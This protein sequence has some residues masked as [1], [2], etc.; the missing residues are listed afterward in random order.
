MTQPRF[1]TT[2][3]CYSPNVA[4]RRSTTNN[5]LSHG[6]GHDDT[7]AGGHVH[8]TTV[9][10]RAPGPVGTQSAKT[11]RERSWCDMGVKPSAATIVRNHIPRQSGDE[12][13]YRRQSR[14]VT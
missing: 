6:N 3:L 1:T 10:Q 9:E 7:L 14:N 2:I 11:I 4:V 12:I 13:T 8:Y 5:K